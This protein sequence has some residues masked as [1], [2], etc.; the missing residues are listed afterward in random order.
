MEDPSSSQP[1]EVIEWNCIEH[2]EIQEETVPFPCWNSGKAYKGNSNT[3]HAKGKNQTSEILEQ[4]KALKEVSFKILVIIDK[5]NKIPIEWWQLRIIPW[6]FLTSVSTGLHVIFIF[7]FLIAFLAEQMPG[8]RVDSV[9]T[10]WWVPSHQTRPIKS[11]C[12]L[13]WRKLFIP[14]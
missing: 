1:L 9:L 2:L 3:F 6:S 10:L 7:F 4:T 13:S 5:S 14:N 12:A 11:Y 8:P